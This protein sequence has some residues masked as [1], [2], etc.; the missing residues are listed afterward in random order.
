[1]ISSRAILKG[2]FRLS[3]VAA[4]VA[5]AYTAFNAWH[6]NVKSYKD[7]MDTVFSYGAHPKSRTAIRAGSRHGTLTAT[8]GRLRHYVVS[9]EPGTLAL[10]G[11]GLFGLAM[12]R[13]RKLGRTSSPLA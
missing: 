6:H 5:G 4:V 11:S 7:A 10:L 13:R 2:T 12:M 8:V 1:M 3:I 9:L